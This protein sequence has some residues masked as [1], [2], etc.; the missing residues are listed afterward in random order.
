MSCLDATEWNVELH[1]I[2]PSKVALG[3]L[4]PCLQLP[5]GEIVEY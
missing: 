3:Y 1:K 2:T 4:Q 5:S